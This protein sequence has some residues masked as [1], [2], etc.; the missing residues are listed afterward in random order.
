MTDA[1]ITPTGDAVAQDA[2]ALFQRRDALVAEMARL[3]RIVKDHVTAYS[4]AM[5]IWG[6]TPLMLRKACEARGYLKG[7]GQ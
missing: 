4:Q 3:D 2:A 5:R 7:N 6:F 1:S